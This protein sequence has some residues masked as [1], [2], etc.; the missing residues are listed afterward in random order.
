MSFEFGVRY[1]AV[2]ELPAPT[3]AIVPSARLFVSYYMGD[4]I[5]IRPRQEKKIFSS[6]LVI[7]VRNWRPRK[8][9]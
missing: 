4:I 6:A 8:Y 9:R 1:C 5:N 2:W 7:Q 3:K